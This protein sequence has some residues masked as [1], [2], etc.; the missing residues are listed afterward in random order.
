MAVAPVLI[1]HIILAICWA[2]AGADS[3]RFSYPDLS[4]AF[5]AIIIPLWLAIIGCI[6]VF[7]F[8]PLKIPVIVVLFV[9]IFALNIV[10]AYADWGINTSR[11]WT[12]DN[13][14]ILVLQFVAFLGAV[15][16]VTPPL[17]T[18]VIRHVFLR[19]S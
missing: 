11:F 9:I 10:L 15:I 6:V 18:I 1:G 17:V 4:L 5:T 3:V 16:A 12:P 8:A 13:E 14:T 2:C 7:G 19:R